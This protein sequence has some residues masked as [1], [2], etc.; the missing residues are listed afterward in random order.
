MAQFA[1]I[2]GR[3][4]RELR[5]D[6][7]EDRARLSAEREKRIHPGLDDKVLVAWNGLAI[8][9]L[10]LAAGVLDEPRYLAAAERAA[11]FLL[12][13]I[14]RPDGLLWHTW[15]AGVARLDA[16]L[17]DYACLANA[18]VTLY[19]ADFD[20]RWIG[21]ALRLA[22]LAIEL[23]YDDARGAFFFTA[24]DG[25][26]LITRQKDF[27]DSSV[28]SGNSM[29]A[30]ALLRLGKLTGRKDFLDAAEGTLRASAALLA[31]SP[32]AAG[33]MLLALD[34]YFGPTP[35]IVI[36]GDARNAETAAALAALRN[37]Y[38]PNKVVACR[39]P[40]S[41]VSGPL[42][43]LFAGKSLVGPQ[44]GVF[45]CENFACREPAFGRA[46]AMAAWDE[47]AK[48]PPTTH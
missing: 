43:P 46:A 45:I 12:T 3:D 8:D 14:N 38:I 48:Q 34:M 30:T 10:S 32:R 15:R 7:D 31:Q 2:L 24:K 5:H 25:E 22:E 28:P 23:F 33:Q 41:K 4:E 35:E 17:D 11:D 6:L 40:D 16:Y 29:A 44:P 39:A 27:Y 47:L 26:S 37:H 21:E 9:A 1:H 13:K 36:I 18:L 19:E 42:D 20:E